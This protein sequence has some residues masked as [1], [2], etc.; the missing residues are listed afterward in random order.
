MSFRTKH[1]RVLMAVFTCLLSF[2]GFAASMSDSVILYTPYTK[3]AVTPGQSVTYV[4]DLINNSK[5]VINADISLNG[6]PAS[7]NYNLKA[8]NYNIQKVSVLAGEKKSLNLSLEVPFKVNKGSYRFRIVAGDFYELPLTI[9]V[10]EQG[11][12]ETEFTSDQANMEG[13]ATS[14]FTYQAM[15][16]NGTAGDQLYALM[17]D[18]PRGWNVT[19]KYL[20]RQVTSVEVKENSNTTVNIEI[21]PPDMTEAGIYK[22]PVHASTNSTSSVIELE[23]VITGSYAIELTTPTGLLSTNIT[24][25]DQ[26]S[27][28]LIVK[29]TGSVQLSDVKLS[30][31]NPI[32]WAVT[33]DPK[34]VDIIKPGE[35]VKVIALIKAARKALAGDYVINIDAKTQEVTSKAQFRISVRTS[36]LWGWVGILI[37]CSALGGVYYLFR[38]YGRR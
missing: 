35:S 13:S 28:E 20:S 21:D 16:R 9:V 30:A 10:S 22:I 8:G 32:S 1:L 33:F 6:L 34:K 4:I 17:A 2:S 31:I 27:I 3:I 24:A 38:K 29:N 7:W 15:L 23:V 36:I 11:T 5:E 18:A 25:G 14:I 37:I 12:F 26:K 19:F